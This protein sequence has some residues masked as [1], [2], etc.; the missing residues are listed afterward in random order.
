MLIEKLAGPAAFGAR[1]DV[2]LAALDA[3]QAARLRDLL[4]LHRLLVFRGQALDRAGQRRLAACFGPVFDTAED[5]PYISNVRA[6]GA[7][8]AAELAFHSDN[9]Y[10]PE[11]VTAITS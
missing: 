1:V 5:T 11:P 9:E 4:H 8:G 2:D 10:C 3:A 6:D 7:L